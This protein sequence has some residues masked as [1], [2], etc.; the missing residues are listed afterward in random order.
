[1]EVPDIKANVN[2]KL[3]KHSSTCNSNVHFT[4]VETD[5]TH[6]YYICEHCMDM[7]LVI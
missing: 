4:A 6:I 3:E 7:Q 5:E 2:E 1:M